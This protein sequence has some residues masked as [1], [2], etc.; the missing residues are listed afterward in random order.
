MESPERAEKEEE[1][2]DFLKKAFAL[3]DEF[4]KPIQRVPIDSAQPQW[5]TSMMERWGHEYPQ[6]MLS[7]DWLN[8]T[9]NRQ[10]KNARKRGDRR[11]F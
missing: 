6:Y 9:S 3:T 4:L 1:E 11:A 10:L 5:S 7:Q 2:D 8:E